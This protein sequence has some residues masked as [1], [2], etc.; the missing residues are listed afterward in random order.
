MNKQYGI[1]TVEVRIMT[2]ATLRKRMIQNLKQLPAT[3]KRLIEQKIVTQLFQTSLWK[4]ASIIGVTVSR[5]FEL[6]TIAIIQKAWN[7]GKTIAIPKCHPE[8]RQLTFYQITDYSE[9]KVGYANIMEPDVTSAAQ[10]DIH[11]IH[12]LIVP[13]ILFDR[14][15][16][17]IGFGGG[18]YDRFLTQFNGITLSLA[19]NMQ[20]VDKLRVDPY[21]KPVTFIVTEDG[22]NKSL[23]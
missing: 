8:N 6:D 20:V 11:L 4:D 14:L 9:L 16:Y 22:C 15:G 13:G 2:K 18:Y 17:R 3:E 12:L 7:E 21:D 23:K 5:D 19:S 10:L 1:M